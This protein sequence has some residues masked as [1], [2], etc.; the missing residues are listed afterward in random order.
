[1]NLEDLIE[2]T[3]DKLRESGEIWMKKEIENIKEEFKSRINKIPSDLKKLDKLLG[4]LSWKTNADPPGNRGIVRVRTIGRRKT[5]ALQA[6]ELIKL[7][8]EES[9]EGV[10]NRIIEIGEY[11]YVLY[12][13][14]PPDIYGG[15]QKW[16]KKN[17]IARYKIGE[18]DFEKVFME[19]T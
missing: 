11:V 10:R 7:Y 2:R 8:G 15:H 19:E 14:Y 17:R 13:V 9:V 6:F 1:M 16:N 4:S 12:Y 5:R 3:T 18:F